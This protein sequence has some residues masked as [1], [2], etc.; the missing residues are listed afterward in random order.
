MQGQHVKRDGVAWLQIPC[1]DFFRAL[2]HLWHIRKAALRKPFCLLVQ[3]G[4]RKV[5][6]AAVGPGDEL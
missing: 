6:R 3:E 2:V 4:A 1:Q 5:P